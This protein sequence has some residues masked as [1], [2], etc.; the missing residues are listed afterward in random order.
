MLAATSFA[1]LTA[2]GGGSTENGAS[3]SNQSNQLLGGTV[4][5][6]EGSSLVSSAV[7]KVMGGTTATAAMTPYA[8]S[9]FLAQATF[10]PTEATIKNMVASGPDIWI[11]DQFGKVPGSYLAYMDQHIAAGGTLTQSQ[12]HEMFWKQAVTGNDQLR[13]RLTLALSEIFVISM[14]DPNIAERLR[15]VGSYYDMLANNAFGNFR[16]LLQ[17]VALHPMMGVYMSHLRNQKES[18]TRLPD[19]NFAR[20]IMQLMT[21]GLYKLN[22]DGSQQLVNG[23]PVDTYTHDDIVGL[24]KVFTGWSFYGPDKNGNRFMGTIKD[25]AWEVNPMQ[26]YPAFHSTSERKFLGVTISGATTGEADLKVALDTLFNHPNVGPFIGKQLIQRLVTSNPSPA[27]VSRVAAAFNNNGAGVRGDMKALIR[28]VL[29]DPEAQGA[30]GGAT[31]KVREPFIRIANWM[32]AFNVTSTSGR[33]LLTALDDPI[34]GLGQAPMRSPSVFNFFRPGYTPPNTAI[35]EA[36]EVAPEMQ[37]M[38]EP[39]SIGYVNYMQNAV[40]YGVGTGFD[41]KPNYANE[42]ALVATPEQLVE[43][44]NLLLLNGSMSTTLRSQMLTALNSIVQPTP[45]SS[46]ADLVAKFKNYRVN[47][48]VYLAMVSPE[49]I[50]QK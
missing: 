45:T 10:G 2:C 20:E 30:S 42:L 6:D 1:V 31:E 32:R 33:Y 22:Q 7:R 35:S 47:M 37:I 44:V 27:Y 49:Y 5:S 40:A 36:G 25:P 4:S 18:A 16:T 14:D 12:F 24:S 34:N 26:N 39:T 11:T 9:R 8:A 21:I 3:V 17:S 19:E 23:K 48:A 46:N 28:A 43:R 50:V 29:L 41:I 38:S 15:G 13:Q